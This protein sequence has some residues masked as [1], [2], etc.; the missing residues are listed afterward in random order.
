[1]YR[2]AIFDFDGTL[3]DSADWF[4]ETM[5]AA[6]GRF[7]YRQV[8]AD[9][10]AAL[11]GLPNREI[12]RRL[13]V[14]LWRMPAIARHFRTEAAANL[15]RIRLFTG[16]REALRSIAGAGVEIVIVSSNSE[17]SIRAVLG[18]VDAGLVT[19]FAC[20]AS[21]FGKARKLRRLLLDS[22]VAA[23]DVIAI[24][25]ETR[26]VDAAKAA[27]VSAAAVTWGY[28][29]RAALEAAQPNFLFDSFEALVAAVRREQF[30]HPARS[31]PL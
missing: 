17:E 21:L 12:V 4:V 9:E 2:L 29:A 1:M 13:R 31:L 3:A 23:A 8:A 18:P 30:L 15:H 19:R 22:R 14:P 28:A 16:A 5:T 10:L 11:R 25:D 7:G 27:G 26:D 6:A 20:G 24:G